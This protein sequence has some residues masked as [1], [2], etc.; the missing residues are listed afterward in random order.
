MHKRKPITSFHKAKKHKTHE[1]ILLSYENHIY[2]GGP[3]HKPI[4]GHYN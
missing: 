4:M 2:I 3:L 1:N